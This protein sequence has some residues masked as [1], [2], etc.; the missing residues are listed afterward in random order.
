MVYYCREVLQVDKFSFAITSKSSS[1]PGWWVLDTSCGATRKIWHVFLCKVSHI[2]TLLALSGV[3][4]VFHGV[5]TVSTGPLVLSEGTLG[6]NCDIHPSLWYF[7]F[8]VLRFFA[9]G[10]AGNSL[11]IVILSLLIFFPF[12]LSPYL[13]S[14]YT[15]AHRTRTRYANTIT[16][17]AFTSRTH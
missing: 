9:I 16:P 8:L 3:P 14:I 15:D 13:S 2:L 11:H 7:E 5:S 17:L 12:H 1:A 6:S 4:A 10:E